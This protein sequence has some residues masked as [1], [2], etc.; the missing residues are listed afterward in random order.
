MG[1]SREVFNLELFASDQEHILELYCSKRAQLLLQ[2]LLA[3]SGDRNRNA[4][5]NELEKVLTKVAL[6]RSHMVMCSPDWG[7]H[8]GNNY[9]RTL[10]EKLT[11]TSIHLSDE[12]IYGP[13]AGRR[14]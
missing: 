1:Y 6:E 3:L 14:L 9:W 12:A 5:F 11:L 4:R 2:I 7:A 8:G 13:L 10:L